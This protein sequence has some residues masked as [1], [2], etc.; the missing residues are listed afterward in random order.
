MSLATDVKNMLQDPISE[1]HSN[2][3]F[4]RATMEIG[5][6]GYGMAQMAAKKAYAQA[7]DSHAMIRS[8]VTSIQTG[9]TATDAQVVELHDCFSTNE[10]LTY[11]A[12]V[13]HSLT[14]RL[15]GLG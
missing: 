9:M 12:L 10:L 3:V 11:E 5:M 2:I 4:N 1:H 8:L 13:S 6:V 15:S 7:G 14:V